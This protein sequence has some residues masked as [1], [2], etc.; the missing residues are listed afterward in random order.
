MYHNPSAYRAVPVGVVLRRA[1]GVT[2]WQKW[3]WTAKVPN[4]GQ[5]I[6]QKAL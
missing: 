4:D 1:P 3:T 5:R 2:R 6:L